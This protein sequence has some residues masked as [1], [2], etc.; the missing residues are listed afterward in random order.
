VAAAGRLGERRVLFIHSQED[1][2]VAPRHSEQ[3]WE[4][5]GRRHAVWRVSGAGH[6]RA[7]IACRGEYERRVLDFLAG[8]ALD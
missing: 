6:N 7:W 4:A 8:A 3:L 2:R 1:E 5:A